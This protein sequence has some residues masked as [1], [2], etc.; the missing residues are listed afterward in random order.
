MARI[1]P[2][3]VSELW[4]EKLWTAVFAACDPV[5]RARFAIAVYFRSPNF[6]VRGH[7]CDLLRSGWKNLRVNEIEVTAPIRFSTGIGD[8]R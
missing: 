8:D 6:P 7:P 3:A 5:G 2:P 1:E 4:R